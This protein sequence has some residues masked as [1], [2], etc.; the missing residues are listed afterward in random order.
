MADNKMNNGNIGVLEKTVLLIEK[1]GVWKILRAIFIIGLFLYI[2]YNIQNLNSI[3]EKAIEKSVDNAVKSEFVTYNEEQQE[4]HD[5]MVNSRNDANAKM[6]DILKHIMYETDCDRVFVLEFHN[7]TNGMGGLPF[8]YGNITYELNAKGISSIS[9][10]YT[11]F[12]LSRFPFS[13]FLEENMVWSGTIDELSNIDENFAKRMQSNGAN[14]LSIVQMKGASTEIG[15]VGITYCNDRVP[16]NKS[17]VD[18][19]LLIEAQSVVSLLDVNK[20]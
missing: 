17:N 16:V 18:R 4:Q 19:E 15:Y 20:K 3:I 11:N 1:Y 13:L 8:L 14:Y 5:I 6:P 12:L 2:I 10:D 7:G 9:D